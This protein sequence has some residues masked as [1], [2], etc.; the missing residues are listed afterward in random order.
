MIIN[1]DFTVFWLSPCAFIHLGYWGAVKY[2]NT[3][4]GA[5]L[6]TAE[7]EPSVKMTRSGEATKGD[8]TS[9]I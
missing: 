1:T 7:A 4:P 2:V 3:P 5:L 8:L 9:T 6:R